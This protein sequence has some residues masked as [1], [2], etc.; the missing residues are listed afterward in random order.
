MNENT[1]NS[2]PLLSSSSL[3]NN[4]IDVGKLFADVL[5]GKW[6]VFSVTALFLVLSLTYSL[7]ATPIYKTTAMLQVEQSS[8]GVLAFDEIGDMFVADSSTDTEIFILRSRN[9]VGQ[10]IDQLD[11]TNV[12]KPNYFP[13]VG[14]F[15][16]RRHRSEGLAPS[17]WGDSYAWGGEEIRL[18]NFNVPRNL[19]M[20]E[21]ILTAQGDAQYSLHLD[22]EEILVGLLGQ[23]ARNNL[24][25]IDINLSE[26]NARKGTEF[27]LVKRSRLK[28]IMTL[29]K[30]FKAVSLGKETGIIELSLLG[31]DKLRI[32]AILGALSTN[33]VLQNVKRL[34]AEAENSLVFLGGHIP[35]VRSSL[36]ESERA[37]NIYRAE[38]DSVDLT[39]ETKSLLESL[40]VLEAEI[41]S[42][43]IN[44]ADISR[45]FTP[46]HPNYLA[47]KLQQESLVRQRNLIN[48]KIAG[49]P[50]TQQ[51]ILSLVRDYEV[52]QAIYISLQNKSQELE[53]L[54]ASTVG[55][56]RVIDTPAVLPKA[57]SPKRGLIIVLCS[58][59]GAFLSLLYVLVKAAFNRGVSNPQ[60]FQD[61]G[62]NVYATIPISSIQLNHDKNKSA[63][64][65]SKLEV[66]SSDLLLSHSYPADLSVEAI[67][68]LR[69]SLHFSRLESK[70]NVVM[71][72][73]GSAE[74]GKSFLSSNLSVVMAQ[75]GMKILVIDADMRRGY[76]HKIFSLDKNTGLSDYL[77]GDASMDDILNKTS[78]DNL[79]FISRGGV[80]SNPSELLMSGRLP[81]MLEELSKKYDL[82]VIDTPPIL[83]VTDAAIVG[84]YAGLTMMVVRFEKSTLKEIIAASKRLQLSGISV[85]GLVFNAIEAKESAYYNYSYYNYSYTSRE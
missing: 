61:I 3:S 53:V 85:K 46:E 28:A 58:F 62:Y 68:S 15:F 51:T 42:M 60:D 55:N 71:I 16:A 43:A 1:S 21:F 29:Q 22:N 11:L 7:I 23:P 84:R 52:N 37:L 64:I 56:V 6:I 27:T 32:S 33:Y 26:L 48:S 74:V 47:F 20:K 79:D 72:S 54:K 35:Q 57:N 25:D 10:A 78:V 36:T 77:A 30:N 2:N 59:L 83:A 13:L 40:V 73:S 69:T 39:L 65:K 70:N 14:Q 41:S 9:I 45:R 18:S 24:Y 50:E 66:D 67:R 38:H 19:L 44:E 5:D 75:S 80:P 81:S 31:E 17:L 49:L 63:R 82:V 4:T 34:A 76:L 8:G 12:I